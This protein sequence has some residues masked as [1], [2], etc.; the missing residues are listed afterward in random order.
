MLWACLLL[1]RLPLDVFAPARASSASDPA[2]PFAVTTGGHYPRIV[3]ADALALAAGIRPGELVSAALALAP[4]IVLRERDA[5]AEARALAAVATWATQFS[6]AISLAPPDAVLV[7]IG[8]S[9]RLFGGLAALLARLRQGIRELGYATRWAVAP[10]AAAALLFARA[11]RPVAIT[12]STA[13]LPALAPLPLELLDIDPRVVATLA[14]AGIATFG[15]ACALPRAAL[16]RRAGTAL[17][18][19]LDHARGIVADPR[20]PFVPPARYEGRLELA[21]PVTD[22]EALAF[23]VHRLVLELAGW[24]LGRGLG[25]I[26]LTLT[27]THERDGPP[28]ARIPECAARRCASERDGP[29]R[30]RIP[31]FP[32]RRRASERDDIPATVV[33][34]ALAA[35]AREPAHL[36]TVLRERL[37]RVTL[38]A[39]VESLLLA[40]Q[41][42]APLAA[43]NLGLLPGDHD[44]ATVP[45]LDRL[46]ARLGE[47]SVT[48]VALHPEHRPER[49]SRSSGTAATTGPGAKGKSRAQSSPGATKGFAPE[50][51]PTDPGNPCVALVGAASAANPNLRANVFA[52]EGGPATANAPP[53]FR[54]LPNAPRP[55]WLLDTP[56]PL[57]TPPDHR[58]WV[59]HDGPERIESGWWDGN[60]VRRDY[61]V[62]ERPSGERIWIYRDGRD[63]FGEGDGEWFVQGFF[64]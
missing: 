43:R 53:A 20:P 57:R 34:F 42:V 50:G 48:R 56:R 62:A 44:Q 18:A 26:E 9:L 15:A 25:V 16:A 61:F 38:P 31:L 14:G 24:L 32:A 37:A 45:L 6:P 12:E 47:A 5:F 36:V 35:P 7:E 33:A 64:A 4:G 23:A 22:T 3:G 51:A 1:P 17:I 60:D 13:L 21:A 54:L 28:R 52:P 11:D 27:L 29:P 58:P 49:A 59:L 55:L 40:S 30:A 63:G 41:R 39:P 8:G 19:A 2:P 10:T 46:R